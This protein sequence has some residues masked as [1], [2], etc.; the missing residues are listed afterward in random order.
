MQ[1]ESSNESRE[2]EEKAL[3]TAKFKCKCR[4]CGVL[5]HKSVHC[6]ARKN[7]GNWH[8]DANPKPPYFI[9][10]GKVSHDKANYFIIK[11][12]NEANGNG[13]DNLRTGVVGTTA[14]FL[15]N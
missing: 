15:F 6:K 2:N 9:Y 8:T 7:H 5:G 1:S 13:D 11:R 14:D 10:C 3:I 4:N 12:I